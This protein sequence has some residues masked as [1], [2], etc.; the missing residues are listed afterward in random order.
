MQKPWI[1]VVPLVDEEKKSYWMLPG[2]MEGI[3]EAGG[4]PLMLPLTSDAENLKQLA[5]RLDGF[6]FTGGHDVSP[7]L[8]QEERSPLCGVCCIERDEMEKRLFDLAY[9]N[10]QPML[11][12]CRGIQLINV[13][14]GGTLYQDLETEYPSGTEHHQTPPYDIGVHLVTIGKESPLYALLGK[15]ECMVNSYHHQAIR[16][17]APG[18]QAMAVSEDGLVEAVYDPERSFLWAVQWHPEFSYQKNSDSRRIF[19]AFVKA[20]QERKGEVAQLY[21]IE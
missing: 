7:K 18:L 17:L 20:A 12:I 5:D 21:G 10:D 4:I 16:Q 1:G 8:Y 11:G 13:L 6:L 14:M 3:R 15:H 2:Y 19:E 9:Q